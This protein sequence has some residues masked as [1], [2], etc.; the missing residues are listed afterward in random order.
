MISTRI[1][2]VRGDEENQ[3]ALM[4]QR[5]MRDMRSGY[6]E[7]YKE[8]Y[9]CVVSKVLPT[10]DDIIILQKPKTF[11]MDERRF[12][13]RGHSGRLQC[14]NFDAGVLPHIET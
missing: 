5:R 12:G 4:V 9:L 11:Y 10:S 2:Q 6:H 3:G 14:R 7:T 8:Y 13:T 1:M